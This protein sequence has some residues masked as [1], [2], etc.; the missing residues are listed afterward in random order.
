[1][2][3]QAH[4]TISDRLKTLACILTAIIKI[5]AFGE[6]NDSSK[7]SEQISIYFS[8]S[9][10]HWNYVLHW[11]SRNVLWAIKLAFLGRTYLTL[12]LSSAY[13]RN[14]LAIA[15][16]GFNQCCAILI[17]QIETDTAGLKSTNH[18]GQSSYLVNSLCADQCGSIYLHL[19][20]PAQC[21]R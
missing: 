2:H 15:V 9:G 14:L 4:A 1:M 11:N 13:V 19:E 6:S 8:C 16:G 17:H 21:P 12:K 20:R 10:E 18:K 5:S 3:S 7:L